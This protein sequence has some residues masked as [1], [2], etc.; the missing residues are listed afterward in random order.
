MWIII[1][2][3]YTSWKGSQERNWSNKYEYKELVQIG[4]LIFNHDGIYLY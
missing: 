3:E 4:Y 1:D 2:T